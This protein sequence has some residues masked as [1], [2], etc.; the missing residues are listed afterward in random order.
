MY[1][2]EMK[3]ISVFISPLNKKCSSFRPI[4]NTGCACHFH[5]FSFCWPF[6]SSAEYLSKMKFEYNRDQCYVSQ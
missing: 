6:K 3:L 2:N 1:D 5:R 4:L